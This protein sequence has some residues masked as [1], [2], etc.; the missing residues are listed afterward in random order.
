MLVL[1]LCC[2]ELAN[3]VWN[4]EQRPTW[5]CRAAIG[6]SQGIVRMLVDLLESIADFSKF[7]EVVWE[8]I[9]VR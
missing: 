9:E 2:G 5:R 1:V 8:S 6:S 4:F 3:A 7:S